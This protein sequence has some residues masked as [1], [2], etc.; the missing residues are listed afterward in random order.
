MLSRFFEIF[1]TGSIAG[2]SYLFVGF[3]VFAI[4]VSAVKR[5]K[6]KNSEHDFLAMHPDAAH[7]FLPFK[8]GLTSEEMKVIDV[9][10]NKPDFFVQKNKKGILLTPGDHMLTVNFIT[11]SS[12][13]LIRKV[14]SSTDVKKIEVSIN[15]KKQYT[16]DF[17]RVAERFTFEELQAHYSS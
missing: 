11:S 15:K 2:Y 14:I 13:I 4:V 7:V 10:G 8:L 5:K 9:D 1:F 6:L 3:I 17:D 16:L 12:G